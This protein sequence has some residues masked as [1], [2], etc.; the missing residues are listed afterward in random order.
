[1]KKELFF[2]DETI[3]A[4]HIGRGGKYNNQGFL[5]CEGEHK[6]GDFTDGLFSPTDEDGDEI[7]GEYTD[8]CGNGVGLTT[9]DVRSGI[10]TIN[11][12]GE[13]DTTY[14]TTMGEID[15]NGKEAYAM[16]N[17]SDPFT[18][19]QA[20]MYFMSEIK[21]EEAKKQLLAD[22]DVEQ[23]EWEEYI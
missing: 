10:G 16:V 4:F 19:E 14:T 3:I 18:S 6:I 12:D 13:Y 8:D 1:M 9:E 20:I 22:L 7:D 23:E 21:N 11:I 5:T 2:N 17:Y 15:P